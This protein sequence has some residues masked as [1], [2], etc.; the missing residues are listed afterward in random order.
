MTA[1]WRYIVSVDRNP[2]GTETWGIREL[3]DLGDGKLAWSED[4]IEPYGETREE[5][6]ESVR[7]MYG[8]I[9]DEYFDTSLDPPALAKP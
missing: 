7:L 1:T 3:H 4:F 8:V 6:G 5:L 9:H 2:D